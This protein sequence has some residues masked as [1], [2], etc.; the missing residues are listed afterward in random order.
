M[1]AR[2]LMGDDQKVDV[3]YVAPELRARKPAAKAAG[4]PSKNGSR[5]SLLG[6]SSP[7]SGVNRR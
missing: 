5:R 1:S 6:F 2:L 4:H 3:L 7:G